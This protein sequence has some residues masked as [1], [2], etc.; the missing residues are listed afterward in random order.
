MIVL[1]FDASCINAKQRVKELNK[2]EAWQK[3]GF[4]K[5]VSSTSVEEEH[6]QLDK[7]QPDKDPYRTQRLKKFNTY[8]NRDTA[9]WV[10]GRSRLGI[11]TKLGGKSTKEEMEHIAAILF[12]NRKWSSLTSNQIRDVM[13]LHTHWIYKRDVFVTLNTKDFIGKKEAKRNRLKEAFGML[14]KTPKETLDYVESKLNS[15]P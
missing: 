5:I 14:V 15:K 6:L 4:I 13:A 1:T 10:L 8:D 2:L 7:E 3:K 12:P 11:S 9:Y